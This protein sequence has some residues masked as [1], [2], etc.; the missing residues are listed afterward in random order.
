[1]RAQEKP[2]AFRIGREEERVVGLARRV[3]GREVEPGE[4]VVVGLDVRPF[5]DGEAHV[6]EDHHQLFPHT[7]DGTDLPPWWRGFAGRVA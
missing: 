1:M 6:R 4:I 3:S 2:L 7:A 5:G